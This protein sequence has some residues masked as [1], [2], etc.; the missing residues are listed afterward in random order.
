MAPVGQDEAVSLIE[1]HGDGSWQ[2][3]K[4]AIQPRQ[5]E[6]ARIVREF[7]EKVFGSITVWR[8]SFLVGQDKSGQDLASP[9]LHPLG[10]NPPQT[11]KDQ[12]LA[13]AG[14]RIRPEADKIT[15][16]GVLH[17]PRNS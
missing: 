6:T 16:G 2:E 11:L 10:A 7:L 4:D 17:Q 5:R 1:S 3:G 12:V 14:I 9:G 8:V 13:S 15:V